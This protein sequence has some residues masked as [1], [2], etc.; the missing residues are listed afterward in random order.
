MNTH[1]R[2]DGTQGPPS[3]PPDERTMIGSSGDTVPPPGRLGVGHQWVGRTLGRYRL[4][5]LLGGGGMGVVYRA[6]DEVI[7]RDVAV[8]VLPPELAGD[9]SA[10]SR[11]LSEA[12]AAGRLSHAN[13]VS[14]HEI[15]EEDGTQYLVMELVAGGSLGEE[16]RR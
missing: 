14:L 1:P 6:R 15:G 3:D 2:Q 4:T 11:F 10:L 9:S 12:K 16:V 13:V 8:K 5:G 7:E